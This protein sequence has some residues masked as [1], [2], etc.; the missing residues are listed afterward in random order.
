MAD[1]Q[2]PRRRHGARGVVT[3]CMMRSA[4][5]ARRAVRTAKRKLAWGQ[6]YHLTSYLQSALWTVPLIAIVLVLVT[7]PTLRWID[8]W[9]DWQWSALAPQGAQALYQTVIT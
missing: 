2:A 7:V 3:A 6:L 4:V 9:L 8:G 1:A 5:Y